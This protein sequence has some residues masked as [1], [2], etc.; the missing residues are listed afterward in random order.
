MAADAAELVRR[1]LAVT[2]K[3]SPLVPRDV[4]LKLAARRR[5]RRPAGAELLAGVHRRRPG[6]DRPAGR[7]GP[8]A[9]H[10]APAEAVAR[11]SP[12]PSPSM[13]RER[14][15]RR[16]L[17]Q[18]QRRFRRERPAA[19]DRPLRDSRAGAG[20]GRLSQRSCRCRSA[21]R[22]VTLVGDQV[23]DHLIAHHARGAGDRAARSPWAPRERATVDLVDQAGRAADVRGFVG[24]LSRRGAAH[25]LAAA[26][27]AGPRAH[28]LLR[29]GRRRAG[30]RAAPPHLA[31]D[32]RRRPAG[33]AGHL[34]AGRVCR[35]G[36]SR[37]SAPAVDTYH[38]MEFDGGAARPGALP[39]AHAAAVPDPAA[40]RR[41]ARTSTTCSTRWT[42]SPPRSAPTSPRRLIADKPD[43]VR[44]LTMSARAPA[45]R[46]AP[47]LA[48]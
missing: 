1:A 23:R 33:P 11:R 4:A 32:P 6:G 12:T 20:G 18:R 21:E 7:T 13:A 3:A 26:A 9:R 25:R 28:D 37:P 14:A 46:A 17:R 2:L 10:R 36:C 43:D 27:R 40:G 16:G 47:K 31:D 15:V 48:A 29:V 35:R 8:P 34:R 39:G 42:S 41:R 5:E 44:R 30:R 38:S 45:R 24:H 19:G 22:L